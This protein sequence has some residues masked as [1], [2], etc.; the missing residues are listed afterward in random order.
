MNPGWWETLHPAQLIQ[1]AEDMLSQTWVYMSIGI[2]ARRRNTA[3]IS[4][5]MEELN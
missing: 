1:I 2:T 4:E 5:K 3:E